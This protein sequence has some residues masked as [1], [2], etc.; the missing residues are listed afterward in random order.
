VAQKLLIVKIHKNTFYFNINNFLKI[1]FF[2][3]KTKK[4][5]LLMAFVISLMIANAQRVIV[6]EQD[7]D[8]P[9]HSTFTP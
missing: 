6:A 9:G 8:A 5:F 1:V 7:F 4:I 2:L 3:M